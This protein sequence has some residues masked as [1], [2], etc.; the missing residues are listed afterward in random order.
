MYRAKKDRTNGLMLSQIL[1]AKEQPIF[2]F[3]MKLSTS[4]LSAA[5][6][7]GFAVGAPAGRSTAYIK[8]R[9]VPRFTDVTHM[10]VMPRSVDPRKTKSVL[11]TVNPSIQR[12]SNSAISKE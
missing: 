5:S 8:V 7:R 10:T 11:V 4:K 3:G 2:G 1:T 12:R 9:N 6:T